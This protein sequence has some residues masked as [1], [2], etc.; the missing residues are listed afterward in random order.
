MLLNHLYLYPSSCP[1]PADRDSFGPRLGLLDRRRL[2]R[3]DASLQAQFHGPVIAHLP[4]LFR[5][6]PFSAGLL[7]LP[8]QVR[9]APFHFD[10]HQRVRF[11][12]GLPINFFEDQLDRLAGRG[13]CLAFLCLGIVA[14]PDA[15]QWVAILGDQF[16]GALLA[17][18]ESQA[19]LHPITLGVVES[20]SRCA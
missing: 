8:A 18:L 12:S 2:R 17:R 11:A 4:H 5:W 15:H 7:H 10:F 9:L 16:L 1:H 20:R 6:I 19:C 13:Q 14:V 3:F